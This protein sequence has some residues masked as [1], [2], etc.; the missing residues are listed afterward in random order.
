MMN[1]RTTSLAMGMCLSIMLSASAVYS[2]DIGYEVWQD[3]YNTAFVRSHHNSLY[4]DVIFIDDDTVLAAGKR[5]EMDGDSAIGIRY[6]AGNGDKLDTD[7]EWYLFEDYDYKPGGGTGYDYSNDC[8]YGVHIDQGG[9]TWFAGQS[10]K[11][12]Y[13]S[14]SARWKLPNVWKYASSYN[15]PNPGAPD[16]PDLRVYHAGG[17]RYYD[18]NYWDLAADQQGNIYAVGRFDMA[19]A[20]VGS[21]GYNWIISKYDSVGTPVAGFPIFLDGNNLHDEA[22]RVVVDSENNFI[23]VGFIKTDA[24]PPGTNDWMVR[25]YSSDGTLIWEAVYDFAGANDIPSAVVVD[26]KDNIIVGGSRN[27][28]NDD[29]WYIVKYAKDGNG[30]GGATI[31]WEQSWDDGTLLGGYVYDLLVSENDNIYV[32][33]VQ[34]EHNLAS[35]LN[36]RQPVLQYRSGVDGSLLKSMNIALEATYNNRPDYEH[37]YLIRMV[38][39]EGKLALA[40]YTIENGSFPVSS[41]A[42]SARIIMF[43]LLADVNGSTTG[44]GTILSDTLI[45]DV[46]YKHTVGFTV[47]PDPGN[48]LKNV[49][50]TCPAGTLADNGDGTW[51]YTTGEI[52]DDCTVIANFIEGNRLDVVLAGNGRGR[53]TSQPAGIDCGDDCSEIYNLGTAVTLTA[54]ALP[55]S[56]FLMWQFAN[57]STTGCA[58][59]D[60]CTFTMDGPKEVTARFVNDF[61]WH[62][63]LPA[64]IN[65]DKE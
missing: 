26:S 5:M 61:P 16:R 3:S 37:N 2:G 55:G 49:T 58:T 17:N 32:L 31:L 42:R 29:D 30:S 50:G 60:P 64:I 25:K 21:A 20:A 24:V 47:M 43:D 44:N 59:P 53:V 52:V 41:Y 6:N 45:E 7:P 1:P 4:H 35:S 48:F 65:K 13:N 15:N 40:G 12:T 46:G 14:S 33:G 27:D 18:G 38:Q 51:N 39:R 62:L 63:M 9:N 19:G 34:R 11:D 54:E 23:V 22:R 10:Y 36:L 8:F 57:Y 56:E 28:S